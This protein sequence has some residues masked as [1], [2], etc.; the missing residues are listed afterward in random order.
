MIEDI[1]KAFTEL[2]ESGK[3]KHGSGTFFYQNFG[4]KL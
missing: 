2:Y 4:I 3:L 1:D